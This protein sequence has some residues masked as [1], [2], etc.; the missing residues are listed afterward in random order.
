M[1]S[2]REFIKG[3]KVELLAPRKLDVSSDGFNNWTFMSVMTWGENPNGI[4]TLTVA[5]NVRVFLEKNNTK[6]L[7][8][9]ILEWRK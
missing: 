9:K 1:C 2:K 6:F 8:P 4:W 5:D 7:V 3:T